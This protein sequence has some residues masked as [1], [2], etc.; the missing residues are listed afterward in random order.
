MR[1][2]NDNLGSPKNPTAKMVAQTIVIAQMNVATAVNAGGNLAAIQTKR[3]H[4]E[5]IASSTVHCRFGK[6]TKNALKMHRIENA[7][8]PS[9]ISRLVGLS[10]T[11]EASAIASGATVMVP[12]ASEVNQLNQMF[13]AD[14]RGPWKK[15]NP[16]V[17]MIP[18]RAVPTAVAAKNPR[19]RRN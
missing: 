18:E 5:I 11:N 13:G 1:S 19:T 15:T 9:A 14:A 2:F 3:G 17:P 10:R 16:R 6:K 4:S 7:T 12:S 8:L